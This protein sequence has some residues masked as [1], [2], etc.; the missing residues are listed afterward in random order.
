MQ[1]TAETHQRPTTPTLTFQWRLVGLWLRRGAPLLTLTVIIGLWEHITQAE[2]VPVFLLPPP[3][4]I[5]EKFY[6]T[7]ESGLLWKHASVTLGEVLIGLGFGLLI[8]VGLGYVIAKNKFL[9]SLLS[10]LVIAFQSTPV[11]AYAPILVIVFGSGPEGKVITSIIV[12]FFPMLMNTVVGIRSVPQDL[13][14]LMRSSNASAWQT[15]TKLELP[16]AMPVLMTGVKTGATL[17]VIGAVVGEFVA[18]NAGLGFLLTSASYSYDTALR[19][20]AALTLALM[21]GTLYGVVSLIEHRL[22]NWQRRTQR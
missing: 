5:A 8:G 22:L 18:A 12:V 14:D 19:Y 11:V 16:A 6:T 4:A 20:V 9:E 17:A 13:R 2:M 7:A 15:F 21:A 3:A 10:P 1:K